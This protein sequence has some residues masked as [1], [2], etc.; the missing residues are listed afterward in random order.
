M[1]V[2]QSSFRRSAQQQ[3]PQLYQCRLWQ[4]V[5]QTQRFGLPAKQQKNKSADSNGSRCQRLPKVHLRFH[6]CANRARGIVGM[7]VVRFGG[8]KTDGKQQNQIQ[9]RRQHNCPAAS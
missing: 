8:Q 6:P 4:V 3:N 9:Y 1:V 2:F 7:A 5:R